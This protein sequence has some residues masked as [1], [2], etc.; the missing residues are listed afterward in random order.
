MEHR[1]LGSSG[2]LVS[3]ICLGTMTFGTPVAE[4]DA[5]RLVHESID[6]GVNFIDTANCYEGYDRVLGSTGG[7]AEE[8]TGKAI[9]D[10][11][12]RVVLATK[13]GAP[14]GP[15]PQDRG[16]S[17]LHIQREIEASLR[18]L[19]T[20]VIDLYIIHW[21][22]RQTPL[23]ATLEALDRVVRQ[24]KARYVGISNH[25]AAQLCRLLWLSEKHGWPRPVSSQIPF[26]FLRRDFQYDLPFCEEFSIGVTPYQSLQGGLLT[27]KYRRDQEAPTGSR[28]AEKPE[29]VWERND[30]LYDTLEALEALAAE[31]DTTPA[32]YA[33]AWTLAQPAMSSLVVGAK[34]SEQ[35]ADAVAATEI[36]IPAEHFARIDEIVPPP[37]HQSD[38]IR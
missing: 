38:P 15:G 7:V 20:D 36:E 30:S 3:P 5:I 12:D 14:L 13:V 10:R 4:A 26:S 1:V 27:G 31:I 34:H 11:R 18:R 24:G 17:P 2:L 9:A 29:W 8:I 6:Q 28:A 35:V 23:E 22:D 21:P 33:L 32:R 37:W 19:G 16:L 25:S